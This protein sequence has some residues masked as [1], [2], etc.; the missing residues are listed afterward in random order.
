MGQ[1]VLTKILLICLVVILVGSGTYFLFIQRTLSTVSLQDLL[2]A[3][4]KIEINGSEYTLETYL[5]RDFMPV[6]PPDGQPLF[7]LIKVKAPGETAISSRI[8]ATRLWVVK[9]KEIWETEFTGEEGSTIGDTLEKIGR[10]GPKWEPGISV[11]VVVRIIDLKSGK[12]YLLKASNQ[13]IHR[14]S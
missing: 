7:A 4:E 11:D 6:S 13:Y 3:P 12:N 10:D 9:G 1:K 5:C 14:T 8:D 2:A